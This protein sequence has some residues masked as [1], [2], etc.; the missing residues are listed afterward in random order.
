[1][2]T[3][4]CEICGAKLEPLTDDMDMEMGIGLNRRIISKG[5]V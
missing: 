1:M 3:R 2:K 4:F 5:L